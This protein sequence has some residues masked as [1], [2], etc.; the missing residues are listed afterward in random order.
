MANIDPHAFAI[1][2]TNQISADG[3]FVDEHNGGDDTRHFS[4]TNIGDD[5]LNNQAV[6]TFREAIPDSAS[7]FTPTGNAARRTMDTAVKH[8]L[9]RTLSWLSLIEQVVD[10]SPEDY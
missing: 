9:N 5:A 6:Q 8:G 1:A 10:I 4:I 3:A 2:L 7:I